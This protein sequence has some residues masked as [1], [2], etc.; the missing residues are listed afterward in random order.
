MA[1]DESSVPS[2]AAGPTT[3]AT[4]LHR[5]LDANGNRLLEGLRVVEEAARF[6]LD[7]PALTAALK[8]LRHD[9]SATVA[10]FPLADRL[11][12]RDTA[13]DVGTRPVGP[14]VPLRREGLA[15]VVAANAQ[16]VKE[17]LRAVEEYGKPLDPVAAAAIERARYRFY[18]L[19]RDL[20][21]ALPRPAATT[22]AGANR[23][24]RLAAARL[25]VLIDGGPDEETFRRTAG[26]LIQAGTPVLQLRDKRLS[27]RDLYRRAG[28]LR[29]LAAGSETLVVVNDRADVAAACDADGVH[30]GQDELP[31][32][33]ARTVVA[34]RLVGVSTHD[35]GQLRAALAGGADYVGLGPTFASPTKAFQAFPGPDY[36]REAVALRA[37]LACRTPMFAI[38]GIDAANLDR[39]L[40]A[41]VD[42][43][44]VA[45]AVTGAADPA[46][47]VAT[48]LARLDGGR[49]R[50]RRT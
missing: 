23:R 6:A 13:G 35:P 14:G 24:D 50:G 39:V 26:T 47:A 5:I 45:S 11:A 38:G 33:A 40:A 29:S 1:S 49:R 7:D 31:L 16:R 44:A 34:D 43:V 19:E 9:V 20:L 21:R 25:Y 22:P 42:R 18:D 46:G 2:A 30:V 10:R 28:L 17:S 48:L 3:A 4:A 36:L 8:A 32:A 15:D 37:A 41:G 12:A 27:D